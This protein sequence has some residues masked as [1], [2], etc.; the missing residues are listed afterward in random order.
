[1]AETFSNEGLGEIKVSAPTEVY[2]KNATLVNF[3]TVRQHFATII[4]LQNFRMNYDIKLETKLIKN[5]FQKEKQNRFIG[6]IQTD[7]KRKKFIAELSSRYI[8]NTKVFEEVRGNEY[9]I[10][11][12]KINEYKQIKDCYIISEMSE[13]DGKKMGIENALKEIIWSDCESIIIF[14]NCDVVYIEKEGF[15]NNLISK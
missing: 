15:N 2:G 10:I 13:F 11:K 5:F 7:K 9:E 12:S 4:F 1:M 14:G 3:Q 6:F 8:L